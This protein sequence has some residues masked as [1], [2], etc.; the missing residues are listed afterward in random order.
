[1]N[2]KSLPVA[3]AAATLALG[4]QAASG[5]QRAQP[6]ASIVS[7]RTAASPR[8]A[9][10][11]GAAGSVDARAAD[12]QRN[13]RGAEARAILAEGIRTAPTAD[14]RLQLMDAMAVSWLYDGDERNAGLAMRAL[15]DEAARAGRPD[16]AAAMHLR[17]ALAA[18][19]LGHSREISGNLGDP[20]LASPYGNASASMA[21]SMAGKAD[22]AVYY[23]GLFEQAARR[24]GGAEMLADMHVV[25]GYA[26][27]SGGRCAQA[28]TD[29]SAADQ[30]SAMVLSGLAQCYAAVGDRA[31]AREIRA[32]VMARPSLNLYDDWEALTRWQLRTIR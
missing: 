13:G 32:R 18:G 25:N 11:I 19:A 7:N 27:L 2:R 21:W 5:Q 30:E 29:L 16:L 10:R 9:Y 20:A 14:A 1:M 4:A 26:L 22:S 12:A 24:D 23:A 28:L 17:M 8:V 3:L 6:T 15:M 31:Q